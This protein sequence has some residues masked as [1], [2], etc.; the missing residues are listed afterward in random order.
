[1]RA[2][3]FD[4]FHTL[5]GFE[6]QWSELPWTSDILGID[7]ATWDAA[8]TTGSRWR[9]VGEERDAF[10]IVSRVAR[11]IDPAIPDATVHEAV[12]IRSERFRN[13]LGRIPP[14]NLATIA[15]LRAAG[16]RLGLV[17][18]ADA[19][20]VAAWANS[21]L[22]GLFDSQ[23]FSCD[24]GCVKPQPE[25][26]T[27]CCEALGVPASQCF[28]VG[29]GGSDELMAARALGMSTVFMSGILEELW[30]DRIRARI[31]QADFH[32]RALPQLLDIVASTTPTRQLA[33]GP[34]LG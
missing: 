9:L 26:F 25:I 10:R 7:R 17:S 6:S 2:V 1:M 34:E 11:A 20:E 21:P 13:S 15:A 31:D 24:V 27:R 30:P 19:M 29:D 22:D 12:A 18:N 33:D 28:F 14:Q 23:V 16:F 32:I 8:L 3:I 5:T 4:L